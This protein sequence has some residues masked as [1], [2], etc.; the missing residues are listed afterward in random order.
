MVQMAAMAIES[1][2]AD[3]VACVMAD[4][5]LQQNRS[6][7]QSYGEK[8]AA[9]SG[10]R[11]VSA[12]SGIIGGNPLMA[13]NARRH[14]LAYGTTSQQF[15]H[16]AVAQRA[17]AQLNPQAQMRSPMTIEDHQ[18]SRWIVEPFRLFDCCLVSNGGICV[19]VT[20]AERARDLAQPAV[21]ISGWAQ[22]NP[23]FFERR[24]E[25]FGLVS[26]ATKAG[27]AALAMAGLTLSDIDVVQVYDCY[28]YTVIVTLEDYGFCKKGEGGDFVSSGVLGPGGSFPL[29]TGGGQLSAYYLRGMTPL[30]EG[31]IQARGQGGAR[32]ADEHDVVLVSNN[33][34]SFDHHANLI[35]TTAS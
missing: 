30:S 15:A 28:T 20:S 26:G 2:Q 32:Q 22:C 1:G 24:D 27:P 16:V 12:A 29:N 17:W 13:M 11:G 4:A 14:M 18:N 5:A 19:I 7:G 23:G 34:G 31:V 6:A 21:E 10:W 25:R 35:L 9:T 8:S 33:G 3:V